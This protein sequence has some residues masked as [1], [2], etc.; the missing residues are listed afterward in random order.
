MVIPKPAAHPV[1]PP[2][3]VNS[4]TGLTALLQRLLD[5]VVGRGGVDRH[6]LVTPRPQRPDGV[7]GGIHVRERR[8]ESGHLLAPRQERHQWCPPR[9]RGIG[10]ISL[11]SWIAT[12][13][14]FLA[15]SRNHIPNQPNDPARMPQS[16][17]VGLSWSQ[18]QGM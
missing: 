15:N 3:S 1:R 16:A 4:R 8:Q 14:K 17:Q 7:G 6:V 11:I 9:F 12:I 18:A 10:I 13:G 5:L 2:I